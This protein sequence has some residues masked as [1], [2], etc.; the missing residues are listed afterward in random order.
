MRLNYSEIVKINIRSQAPAEYTVYPNP[1]K[2][3]VPSRLAWT[4]RRPGNYVIS[5]YNDL[6]QLAYR[7]QVSH[8]GAVRCTVLNWVKEWLMAI[9]TWN[10][11]RKT[12]RSE[13]L[14]SFINVFN[15]IILDRFVDE[16]INFV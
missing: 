1:V 12:T 8:S 5:L 7:K 4:M 15:A 13:H 11:R 3:M 16:S 10:S 2:W 14:T 9:T 6:G